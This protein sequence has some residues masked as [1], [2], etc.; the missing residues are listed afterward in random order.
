EPRLDHPDGLR[1]DRGMGPEQIDYILGVLAVQRLQAEY[2][3]GAD[4]RDLS[5]FLAVWH[6]DGVWDVG[7][8]VFRGRA[9]IAEAVQRQ[10]AEIEAMHHWTSNTSVDVT[11]DT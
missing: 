1:Q 8:A 7:V 11:G 4:K 2:C 10:W 9:A 3:H 5:R 6:E